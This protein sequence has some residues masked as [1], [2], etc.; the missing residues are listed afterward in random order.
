MSDTTIT[1]ANSVFTISVAG[2]F[3][4]PQQLKGYSTEKAWS[5]DQLELAEVQMGVDGRMTSGFTPMPVSQT[6]SL[7]ADS[8]SK[9]LFLAIASA[10]QSA[11]DIYWIS[12]VISLPGT[13]E[14]YNC[15]KG[16]LKNIKQI[17]DAGKV[18]Q[19]GEY[20]IVWENIQPTLE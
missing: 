4:T 6:I 5:T 9:A 8:P 10:M 7:Q 3:N 14:V 18:L 19:A 20:Q 17:V 12:G 1:S 15:V 16:V 13:G 11:R 2:L